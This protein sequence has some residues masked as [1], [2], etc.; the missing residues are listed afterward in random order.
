MISTHSINSK[1]SS[2]NIDAQQYEPSVKKVHSI[3][4]SD[5]QIAP[6]VSSGN[7]KMF[8]RAPMGDFFAKCGLISRGQQVFEDF[9]IQE[10]KIDYYPLI[11]TT[12][13]IE[14]TPFS[15]NFIDYNSS[16]NLAVQAKCLSSICLNESE[17]S[18]SSK[19]QQQQQLLLETRAREESS[20]F[21]IN[22][23]EE[24]EDQIEGG[25]K[26]NF[27]T[28]Q[29]EPSAQIIISGC[30]SAQPIAR[31]NQNLTQGH[32]IES[33]QQYNYVEEDF[34]TLQEYSEIKVIEIVKY[35]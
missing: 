27:L 28:E 7:K 24:E 8:T 6:R 31:D 33:D 10:D 22:C 16:M 34:A 5:S 4:S 15:S 26:C 32:D 3:S 12:Q 9:F 11:K 30:E 14:K 29:I 17:Q 18:C 2:S 20:E 21:S 13:I 35:D 23:G 1:R 19:N 25:H